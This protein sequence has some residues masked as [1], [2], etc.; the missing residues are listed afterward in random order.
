MASNWNLIT[1]TGTDVGKT[2]YASAL[3]ET[4]RRVG[5]RVGVYKPVASGCEPDETGR[6]VASDAV[7][8][9]N[10]AGKPLT[11]Q[12]VCPQTFVAALAPP[13][14]AAAEGRRVDED[15]LIS[16]LDAWIDFDE[17]LIE[18]AGGLFSPISDSMLNLDFAI[19]LQRRYPVKITLV[20]ADRL[21]V[22]HDVIACVRAAQASGL[23]IDEVILNTINPD[24]ST[25]TN[26]AELAKW[27]SIPIRRWTRSDSG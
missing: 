6:P 21:G 12:S 10:A 20:A 24:S 8:L 18:G 22:Q 7:L 16:G 15:Q 11:L 14:A 2:Y 1:G 4:R 5:Q 26:A 9:W 13:Q 19:R 25:P 27:L 23:A 3:A 17:V